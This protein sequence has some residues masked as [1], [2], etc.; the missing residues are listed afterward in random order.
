MTIEETIEA[1]KCL[2]IGKVPGPTGVYAEMILASADVGIR[3]L[4]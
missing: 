2:N 4:M 1:F 3:V